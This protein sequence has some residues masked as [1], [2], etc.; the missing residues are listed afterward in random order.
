[1]K[2]EWFFCISWISLFCGLKIW[3]IYYSKSTVVWF[4]ELIVFLSR[5]FSEH[6]LG[7]SDFLNLSLFNFNFDFLLVFFDLSSE[8]HVIHLDSLDFGD[9]DFVFGELSS[10]SISPGNLFAQKLR[11]LVVFNLEISVFSVNSFESDSGFVNE[12]MNLSSVATFV[13]WVEFLLEFIDDILNLT[14]ISLNSLH[15]FLHD[16]ITCSVIWVTWVIDYAAEL[17]INWNEEVSI[18]IWNANFT[19]VLLASTASMSCPIKCRVADWIGW[20]HI[21]YNLIN[22]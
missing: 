3:L 9:S 10:C 15:N 14:M 1:M 7:D 19:V 2:N 5:F 18:E 13:S 4:S 21:L 22:K 17:L 8:S 11:K 20:S 12:V 16:R 6:S